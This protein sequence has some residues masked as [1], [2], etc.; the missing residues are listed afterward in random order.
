MKILLGLGCM[1]LLPGIIYL[2]Q[3]EIEFK[4]AIVIL[5]GEV[6]KTVISMK[7]IATVF[8]SICCHLLSAQ[9]YTNHHII[10]DFSKPY[11]DILGEE[12]PDYIMDY[13]TGEYF[14]KEE[15]KKN[16]VFYHGYDPMNDSDKFIYDKKTSKKRALTKKEFDSIQFSTMYELYRKLLMPIGTEEDVAGINSFKLVG[17]IHVVEITKEGKIFLYEVRWETETAGME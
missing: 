12:P 13:R 11:V 17:T 2:L 8:L 7:Y 3:K 16:I 1:V 5:I 4:V 15:D 9:D 10:I 6:L 14:V